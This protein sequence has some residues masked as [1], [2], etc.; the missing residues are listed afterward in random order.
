MGIYINDWQRLDA[1]IGDFSA[2]IRL[3]PGNAA[4]YNSRA[5]AYDKKGLAD[6]SPPPAGDP[7]VTHKGISDFTRAIELEP[8]NPIFHHNRGFCFRNIGEYRRAV[9]DYSTAIRLD[10]TNAPAYNNRG[11][12]WRKLGRFGDAIGD[13]SKSLEIESTNV[14][15]F[16]NRCVEYRDVLTT[17]ITYISCRS[18]VSHNLTRSPSHVI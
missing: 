14:K 3:D 9:D 8:T 5:L 2:A 7:R 18:V 16:N 1:A 10:P 12:A 11:Y 17:V 13:Y 15:S 4:S 6:G